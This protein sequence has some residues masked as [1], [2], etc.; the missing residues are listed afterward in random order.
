MASFAISRASCRVCP[1]VTMPSAGIGAV[2]P[3]TLRCGSKE[4]AKATR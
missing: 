3:P 2:Y 1:S 4:H